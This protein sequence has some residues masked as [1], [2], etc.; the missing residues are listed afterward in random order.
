MYKNRF[1]CPVPNWLRGKLLEYN[2][3]YAFPIIPESLRNAEFQIL[4]S[5]AYG[6]SLSN[7]KMNDEYLENLNIHYHKF[8]GKNIYCVAPDTFLNFKE[9]IEK[10]EKWHSNDY[11]EVK[12]VIQ[13]SKAKNFDWNIIKYQLDY[14]SDFFQ[15][16]IDFL[17]FSNPFC[18]QIE[19][20]K[21]LFKRIHD[22]YAVD[23]IH[24]LGAGWNLQDVKAWSQTN[25]NSID[26]I[27]YYNAVDSVDGNWMRASGTKVLKAQKNAFIANKIMTSHEN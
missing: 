21:N 19:Y 22:L 9:T 24:N 16:N 8:S 10:F 26:T 7:R 14:Y 2:R 13:M 15:G 6:L 4:D 12:P 17:F 23:W 25:V 27:A 1:V 3:L 20:P 18:R 5:G 11:H